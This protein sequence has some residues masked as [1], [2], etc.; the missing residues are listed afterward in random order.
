MFVIPSATSI[1]SLF[2][3]KTDFYARKETGEIVA[4]VQALAPIPD[5]AIGNARGFEVTQYPADSAVLEGIDLSSGPATYRFESVVRPITD[6][7]GRTTNTQV[8]TKIIA[9]NAQRQP[10]AAVA[11]SV[12][13]PKESPKQ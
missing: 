10:Q 13:Q 3:I 7:F 5:N 11:R 12:E 4:N 9:D 2:V 8:L 1:T 6:R